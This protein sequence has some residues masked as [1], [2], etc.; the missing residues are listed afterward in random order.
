M[1]LA[2]AAYIH[3]KIYEVVTD[4][5]TTRG[6]VPHKMTAITFITSERLPAI[7][8]EYVREFWE[9]VQAPKEHLDGMKRY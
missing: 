4:I 1:Q 6:A 9:D 5:A 8:S 3:S 2:F 7:G